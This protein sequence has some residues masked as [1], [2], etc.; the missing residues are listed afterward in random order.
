MKRLSVVFVASCL[1]AV[2]AAPTGAQEGSLRSRNAQVCNAV[3]NI[4]D[5]DQ[6]A[7]QY[8]V[9]NS[10]PQE[11]AQELD[12]PVNVVQNCIQEIDEGDDGGDGNPDNPPPNP[13]PVDPKPEPRP[14]PTDPEP[15]P[16]PENPDVPGTDGSDGDDGGETEGPVVV[17]DDEDVVQTTIPKKPLPNTGGVP[18]LLGAGALGLGASILGSRAI[19]PK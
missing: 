7:I 5:N 17:A 14:E 4:I 3:V 15:T 10:S 16:R 1:L 12:I 18:L 9:N 19:R 11:I 6:T 13:N 8:G 2:F